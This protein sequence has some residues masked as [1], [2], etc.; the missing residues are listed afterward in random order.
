MVASRVIMSEGK[1]AILQFS[2]HV[3]TLSI[4]CEIYNGEIFNRVTQKI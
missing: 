4:Y 3:G 1:A 2:T